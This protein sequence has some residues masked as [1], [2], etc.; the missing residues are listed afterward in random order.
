MYQSSV[1]ATFLYQFSASKV[2]HFCI[3][4]SFPF[5]HLPQS[6]LL[7]SQIIVS[8]A[9]FIGNVVLSFIFMLFLSVE[10]KITSIS[11]TSDMSDILRKKLEIYKILLKRLEDYLIII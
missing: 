11:N 5:N 6:K 7:P 8:T 9:L 10:D 2:S 1:M 4:S 3:R